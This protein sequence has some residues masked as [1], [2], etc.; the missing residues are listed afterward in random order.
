MDGHGHQH[1]HEGPSDGERK[2]GPGPV[3]E[4]W[5]RSL[6]GLCLLVLC[7]LVVCGFHVLSAHS[8]LGVRGRSLCCL[9]SF[10]C[11]LS[12]L[13]PFTVEQEPNDCRM[14][15]MYPTYK[16]ISGLPARWQGRY[17][18]FLYREGWRP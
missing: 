2:L 13:K 18:L 5:P 6:V 4:W 9:C 17:R 3:Q 14:T 1:L 8:V 7:G 11:M 16:P 12:Q 15:Y 10:L